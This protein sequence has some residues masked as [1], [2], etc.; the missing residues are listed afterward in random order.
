MR[1]TSKVP[2]LPFAAVAAL[3]LAAALP[4]GCE[5]SEGNQVEISASARDVTAKGQTVTLSATGWNSY[6]W[7]LSDGSIGRLSSATGSTVTY[8]ALS[9][10]GEGGAYANQTVTCQT[11]DSGDG[12][13]A[14]GTIVL[15]HV[16][17]GGSATVAAA[18]N[19]ASAPE[20]AE[21]A[22]SQSQSRLS[23][24]RSKSTLR[25]SSSDT[26]TVSVN[27]SVPNRDYT[28]TIT[29]NVGT[30]EK[31]DDGN[32]IRYTAPGSAQ[33]ANTTLTIKCEDTETHATGQTTIRLN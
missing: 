3:A 14:F 11:T 19:S 33:F 1:W 23:L 10:P 4:S 16:S 6:R 30:W 13:G 29:P 7:S 27:D 22:Q 18:T 5:S 8:T 9:V 2:S 17:K 15:R 24:S 32:V 12:G 26:A 31:A 25:A 28:W 20:V 21:P